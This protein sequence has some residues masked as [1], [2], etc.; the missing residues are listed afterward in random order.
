MTSRPTRTK[1]RT[2]PIRLQR[3]LTEAWLKR[4]GACPC[5]RAWLMDYGPVDLL[6]TAA[7]ARAWSEAPA[8]WLAFLMARLLGPQHEQRFWL[9]LSVRT[10]DG[11][12]YYRDTLPFSKVAADLRLLQ[13]RIKRQLSQRRGAK[14]A[15][16]IRAAR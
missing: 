6:N 2:K 4:L 10:A 9:R 11:A 16:E 15:Q 8:R 7:V 3:R 14:R 12:A 13:R 1:T 5:G